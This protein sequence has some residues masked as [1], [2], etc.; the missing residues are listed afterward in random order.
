[1]SAWFIFLC[2]SSDFSTLFCSS[3][4]KIPLLYSLNLQVFREYYPAKEQANTFLECVWQTDKYLLV[5]RTNTSESESQEKGIVEDVSLRSSKILYENIEVLLGGN[6]RPKWFFVSFR[7]NFWASTGTFLRL[8]RLY[9]ILLRKG[10]KVAAKL[11]Y[12]M[13]SFD[14]N[15]T[16]AYIF[17]RITLI[18]Y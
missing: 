7:R 18:G 4:N 1:M 3:F 11:L 12:T 6:S 17:C 16:F 5:E 13:G 8:S 9:T 14:K 15:S 10:K 2:L